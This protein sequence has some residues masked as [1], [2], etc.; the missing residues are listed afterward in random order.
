[1]SEKLGIVKYEPPV[2]VQLAG[3][4]KGNFPSSVSKTDE[5]R[6]QNIR[7]LEK[8]LDEV[9]VETEKLHGTSVSFVLNENGEMEVC[10]RNLSLKED[11]NNLY[12]KLA[13]KNDALSMLNS[14]RNYYEGKGVSVKSVANS[15]RGCWSGGTKRMGVWYSN[16]WVFP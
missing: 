12:W 16:S 1:M 2:P 7:G 11:E 14:V 3:Q 10:S 4:V 6:V 5:E 8:Y 9:F 15:R 13:K